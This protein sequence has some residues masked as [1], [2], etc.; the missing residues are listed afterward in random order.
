MRW[1][2]PPRYSAWNKTSRLSFSLSIDPDCS[3]TEATIFPPFPKPFEERKSAPVEVAANA[4]GTRL[5]DEFPPVPS[6]EDQTRG[7]N[8]VQHS[9]LHFGNQ[10]Q[11]GFPP[12]GGN[13]RRVPQR[14]PLPVAFELD[15]GTPLEEIR[16]D[17]YVPDDLYR[18]T[19]PASRTRRYEFS[20]V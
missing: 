7:P 5:L 10:D 19:P 12:P 3:I 6:E 11:G 17:P 20:S 15:D 16:V 18:L 8:C 14:I 9:L 4:L 13:A 1:N 2:R